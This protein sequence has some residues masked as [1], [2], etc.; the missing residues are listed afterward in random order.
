MALPYLGQAKVDKILTQASQAYRPE[1][2]ISDLILTPL[3]VK[4]KT[5]KFAKYGKENLRAYEGSLFRAP[6]TRAMSMDYSVSQGN[7][8]C[9]ERAIEKLVPDEFLNNTDDPYDAKRDALW[10]AQ[11]NLA[12][13]KE[14]SLADALGSTSVLTNNTTLTGGDQWSSTG[15]SNPLEDI[16]VGINS[17]ISATGQIPNIAFMGLDVAN[18]LKNH[19]AI[20]EQAKYVGAGGIISEMRLKQMLKDHFGFEDVIIGKAIANSGAPGGADSTSYVWAK[21]FWVAKRNATPTLMKATLGHTV[22]DKQNVVETYREE[23]KVS[24]VIR[25]R[26]SYDQVIMDADLAYLIKDAIA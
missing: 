10:I 16:E 21:N 25:V 5:G 13:N 3:Q 11:D 4:E 24:D 7:Y 9:Q 14:K 12:I 26:E 22:Y 17:V 19:P 6:G 8:L 15:T 18:K 1:N 2:L 20:Q 23:P